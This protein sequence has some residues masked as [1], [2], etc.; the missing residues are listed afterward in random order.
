MSSTN[1]SASRELHDED[2]YVTPQPPIA[3]FLNH[4][5]ATEPHYPWRAAK[6]ADVCAGGRLEKEEMSYPAVLERDFQILADTYDIREDSRAAH[7]ADYLA[8]DVAGQFD[9]ICTNPPFF[10]AQEVISKAI[11]DV[12]P[13]GWVIM[14]LRLNFFGAKKRLQWWKDNMARYSFV[15]SERMGFKH[16]LEHLTPAERRGTDSIEYQHVVWQKHHNPTWCK[17]KPI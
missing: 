2:Y 9:V 3:H 7:I 6:W 4:L 11:A 14:L 12:K 5:F 15:H 17:I 10:L 1:R 8:T 13:G 16:H